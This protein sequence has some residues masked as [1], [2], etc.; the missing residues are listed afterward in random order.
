M[1]TRLEE[2]GKAIFQWGEKFV[3]ITELEKLVYQA[4]MSLGRDI[5]ALL[6]K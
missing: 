3:D 4:V 2:Q 6:T 5:M 1:V